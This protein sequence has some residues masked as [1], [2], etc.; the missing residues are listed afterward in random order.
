MAWVRL[1]NFQIEMDTLLECKKT[2]DELTLPTISQKLTIAAFF[3]AY[4]T[5]ADAFIGQANC[6]LSWIYREVVAVD[7]NAPNLAADQPYLEAHGS[8]A[9]EMVMRQSHAH[10]LY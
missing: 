4:D 5:F 6:P 7:A 1:N 9:Q 10:P 3:E 8:V 2:N